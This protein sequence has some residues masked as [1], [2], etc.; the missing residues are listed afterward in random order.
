MLELRKGYLVPEA[1]DLW[2]L[3]GFYEVAHEKLISNN[4]KEVSLNLSKTNFFQD[5]IL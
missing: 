5:A 4:F 1:E 3:D 2:D